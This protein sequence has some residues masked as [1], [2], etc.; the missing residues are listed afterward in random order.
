MALFRY[1]GR[2]ITGS[3]TSSSVF[4]K[5]A[6]ADSQVEVA[7]ARIAA[8]DTLNKLKHEVASGLEKEAER[9][10]A[11]ADSVAERLEGVLSKL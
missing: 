8:V 4:L 5:T 11:E 9:V 2:K 6:A 1:L 10:H 3:D 7:K